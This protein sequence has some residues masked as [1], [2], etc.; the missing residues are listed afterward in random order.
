[1]TV[2]VY[3]CMSRRSLRNDKIKVREEKK[4]S[5]EIEDMWN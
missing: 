5:N 4:R 2:C 3:V 1:M